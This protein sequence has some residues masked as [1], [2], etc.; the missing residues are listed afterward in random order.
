M[1]GF[2]NETLVSTQMSLPKVSYMAKLKLKGQGNTLC[3]QRDPAKGMD[4]VLD[5]EIGPII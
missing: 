4:L 3:P 2:G 1:S 5:E